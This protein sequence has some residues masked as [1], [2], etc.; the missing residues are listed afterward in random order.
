MNGGNLSLEF[1][2]VLL[3]VVHAPHVFHCILRCRQSK[4]QHTSPSK[5]SPAEEAETESNVWDD[6]SE[7]VNP[8]GDEE[9]EYP[10]V[11][12]YPSFQE[13]PIVLVEEELCPIYDTDNEEEESMPVYDTDIEDVIEEEE[14]FVGKGGFGR[15][16]D[17][18]EDVVVVANDLCSSM[19]QIILR[20]DFE[21]DINTKSHELMSFRKKYYDQEISLW[22]SEAT[23]GHYTTASSTRS[24]YK[25]QYEMGT[26]LNTEDSSGASYR[27]TQFS[28]RLIA[29]IAH[30]SSSG[31]MANHSLLSDSVGDWLTVRMCH[32]RSYSE[33]FRHILDREGEH[34]W[35]LTG[36][37]VTTIDTYSFAGAD[38]AGI[39]TGVT[40][41]RKRNTRVFVH[42][43]TMGGGAGPSV[44]DGILLQD[45]I[46]RK[47]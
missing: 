10:F 6:G 3:D 43:V 12:K 24:S 30:H 22:A 4:Q 2:T 44:K 7:D 1:G 45:Y 13:E 35:L 26:V 32:T 29:R 42:T 38:G 17:N 39:L 20:V 46:V 34:F 15:E 14:G 5:D 28:Y 9:E 19:I 23:E 47:A 36:R 40:S 41:E 27:S 31:P 11:N 25:A 33:T 16:E 21:E 18:I 8:F 37:H